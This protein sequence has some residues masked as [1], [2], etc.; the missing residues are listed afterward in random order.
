M[1]TLCSGRRRSPPHSPYFGPGFIATLRR[2]AL[3]ERPLI[4]VL[5]LTISQPVRSMG[6]A[7]D[8][9]INVPQGLVSDVTDPAVLAR[10][11]R[12]RPTRITASGQT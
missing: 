12:D 3:I 1:I 4:E 7:V 11:T 10:Y 8:G 2:G 6:Q 9:K 5:W